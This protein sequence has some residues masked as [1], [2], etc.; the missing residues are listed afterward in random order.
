MRKVGSFSGRKKKE[1][2]WEDL[3]GTMPSVTEEQQ[4]VSTP[5]A[6]YLSEAIANIGEQPSF[7]DWWQ[8]NQ[9]DLYSG[10]LGSE[11]QSALSEA[12]SGDVPNLFG[13]ELGN[14]AQSA[15]KEALS[16]QPVNVFGGSLG[17]EAQETYLQAMQG[18]DNQAPMFGGELGGEAISAYRE[19]LSG[20]PTDYPNYHTEFMTHVMPAIKESYVGTGAVT[21]SEYGDRVAREAGVWEERAN[22]IRAELYN[23]A[24]QRQTTAAMNY[25][26][27]FAQ[28]DEQIKNRALT[29]AGMYQSAYQS[30]QEQAK[31]RQAVAAGNYQQAYQNAVQYAKQRQL[32]GITSYQQYQ[33]EMMKIGYDNYV[34]QNPNA[35]QILEAALNYLNIPMMAAYQKPTDEEGNPINSNRNTGL[36]PGVN[37]NLIN[38]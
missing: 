23:Q 26:Q 7:N 25:Q 3:I 15:Y 30:A 4:Q 24:K 29:A 19:A 8:Q 5:M 1:N 33:T 35:A 17:Q 32:A 11:A 10:Q 34:Q 38:F 13:G 20:E 18:I 37:Q 36:Q 9:P 2:E 14:Q 12:L 22:R 31:Q 27:A 6:N 21:G 28:R 16:G